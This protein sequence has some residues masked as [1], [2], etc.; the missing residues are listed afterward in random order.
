VLKVALVA[1]IRGA[2]P[3][4]A[5]EFGRRVIPSVVKPGFLEVEAALKK[6]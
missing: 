3:Q 2:S 5:V 1:F 6:K 4:I